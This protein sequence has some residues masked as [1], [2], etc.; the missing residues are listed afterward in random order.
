MKMKIFGALVVVAI[1][2][3]AMMNVNLNKVSNKGDLALANVEALAQEIDTPPVTETWQ[4]I[5]MEKTITTVE[6]EETGWTWEIGLK[7][8]KFEGKITSK[9]PTSSQTV[10]YKYPYKCCIKHGESTTCIYDPC[11]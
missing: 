3:G 4:I 11:F 9:S 6:T 2:A 8:W 1:A 7:V 5:S 10:T